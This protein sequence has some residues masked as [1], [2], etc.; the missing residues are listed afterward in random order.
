ME[1]P[2]ILKTE[3]LKPG[4]PAIAADFWFL[5]SVIFSV[6]FPKKH[7]PAQVPREDRHLEA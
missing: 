3:S 5:S 7:L 4:C 2:E 6:K 1:C